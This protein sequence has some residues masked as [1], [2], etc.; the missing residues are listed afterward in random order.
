MAEPADKPEPLTPEE[1]AQLRALLRLLKKSVAL[2]LQAQ[3]EARPR[4]EPTQAD[5]AAL[6]AR[7][8][9]RQARGKR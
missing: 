2:D 1:T 7:R 3:V 5:I 6:L 4:P 9:R 8:A